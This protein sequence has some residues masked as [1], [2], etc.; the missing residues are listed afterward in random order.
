MKRSE[1]KVRL[2]TLA[3]I[4]IT[5]TLVYKVDIEKRI[6]KR[7]SSHIASGTSTALIY[8]RLLA[9][10]LRFRWSLWNFCWG[11]GS[12]SNQGRGKPPRPIECHIDCG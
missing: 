10:A 12:R 1:Y 9:G 2:T 4:L 6:G 8:V 3:I 11:D 7:M 5:D